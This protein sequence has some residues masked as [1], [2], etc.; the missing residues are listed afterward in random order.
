MLLRRWTP[1]SQ[2]PTTSLDHNGIPQR[3]RIIIRWCKLVISA[4][5]ALTFLGFCI[6]YSLQKE[7]FFNDGYRY[8]QQDQYEREQQLL[9]NTYIQDIS[10]I[11]LKITDKNNIDENILLHIRTKTLIIL[12]NLDTKYKKDIILFLYERHLIQNNQLNLRGINLNNV[13]LIC[14]YDF[15]R[16]YLP[17]VIWSNAVFINCR[18]TFAILDRAYLINA[19][20]INSTLQYASLID[21]N[22]DN[23]HFIKTII[24]NTNFNGASFIQADFLQADIVQGNNF[25]NTD[26]YQAKFT[27]NQWEGKYINIIKHDFSNARL[28]NGTFQLINSEKN[29]IKNGNAEMEC[30]ANNQTIWTTIHDNTTLSTNITNNDTYWGNCSFVIST[31]T[32]VYQN[33]NLNSYKHLIDTNNSI[34][35][36][37]GYASCNQS[38]FEMHIFRDDNILHALKIY[39]KPINGTES[40]RNKSMYLYGEYE[41]NLPIRTRSITIYFGIETFTIDH[42]C[43]FDNMTLRINQSK[44]N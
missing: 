7:R 29:L 1:P 38:Y 28:P 23:S 42:Q 11:L 13:E 32:R 17:E 21:V 15:S 16:L 24:M 9:F 43:Y 30:F 36:F 19:K 10:D 35:S 27:N 3:Q 26:L 22:L 37:L 31:P 18:L 25:T 12:K 14:P 39:S 20:F 5:I 44:I 6:F 4:L 41:Y 34:L 8:K 2:V 40:Y 33:I